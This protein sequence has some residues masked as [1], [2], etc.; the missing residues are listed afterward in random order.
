[1]PPD[2]DLKT[3]TSLGFSIIETLVEQ[4]GGNIDIDEGDKT[5]T[6]VSLTFD[7]ADIKGSSSSIPL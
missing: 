4:L 1:M 7:K 2:F 3:A 5:G 6:N